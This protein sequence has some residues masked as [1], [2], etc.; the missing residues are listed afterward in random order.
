MSV[1]RIS[2]TLQNACSTVDHKRLKVKSHL[3]DSLSFVH[4]LSLLYKYITL[5]VGKEYLLT[6][7]AFKDH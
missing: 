5:V 7:Q 4:Q 3:K 1:R 6:T 2:N